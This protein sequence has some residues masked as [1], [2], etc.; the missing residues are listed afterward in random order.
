MAK[1][2]YALITLHNTP[3]SILPRHSSL[4]VEQLLQVA[5]NFSP[6]ME[7]PIPGVKDLPVYS[8]HGT[9]FC[10]IYAVRFVVRFAGKIK[11]KRR[12]NKEEWKKSHCSY[13]KL[14]VPLERESL[15]LS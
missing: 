7:Q 10:F 12:R 6:L 2:D 3:E 9:S 14:F 13:H 1:E 8:F 5:F 4:Q 15:P 11:R